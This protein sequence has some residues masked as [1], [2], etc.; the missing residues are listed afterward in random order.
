MYRDDS[1]RAAC[2]GCGELVE[3]SK[4]DIV[5]FGTGYR[6]FKCSTSA[7]VADHLVES[8]RNEARQRRSSWWDWLWFFD[9]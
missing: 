3:I 9:D 6:C 1:P 4:A 8:A 7:Q 5:D 2:A